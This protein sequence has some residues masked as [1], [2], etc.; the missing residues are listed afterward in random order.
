MRKG[1][2]T[3]V[4]FVL[5]VICCGFVGNMEAHYYRDGVVVECDND[6]IVIVDNVGEEWICDN[7]Y[8]DVTEGC[9]VRMRMFD[10][11]T[12]SIFDDEIKDVKVIK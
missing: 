1:I 9:H 10:C 3:F 4:L 11:H 5:F 6:V 8:K 2:A 7:C 12:N